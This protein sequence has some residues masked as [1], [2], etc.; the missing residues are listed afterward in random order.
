[1]IN[2]LGASRLGVWMIKHLAAPIQRWLYRLTSGKLIGWGWRNRNILLLT[3]IGRRTGKERTTPVFFLQDGDHVI[4]CNVNPGFERPNPWVLNLHAQP[5]AKIQIAQEHLVCQARE[6]NEDELLHYWPQLLKIWPAY[7]DHFRR[8][9]ERT[10]FI[11][12]V[13]T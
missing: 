6:A 11:L 1:M 10:V 13:V 3:T 5:L 7:E 8:S 12:S 4:L 2:H 9:G